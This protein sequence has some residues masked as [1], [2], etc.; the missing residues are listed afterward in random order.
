M[1]LNNYELAKVDGG[2]ISWGLVGCIGGVLAY[3]I[4][5]FSGYTNPNR[6]NN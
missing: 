1:E 5:V 2:A 6:C 3:L 4:G